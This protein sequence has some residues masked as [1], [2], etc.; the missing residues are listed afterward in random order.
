VLFVGTESGIPQVWAV[1][2]AGG[3]ARWL[4]TS[5][6]RVEA[7]RASPSGP[8]AMVFADAG[9]DENWQ[10][11]LLGLSA[12]SRG[13]RPLTGSPR[14]MH[15]P[16]AWTPDGRGY[17][18][19]SNE[20]DPRFFDV[21][22]VG[23]NDGVPHTLL[24]ADAHHEV[25]AATGD[26]T[27][28]R[29]T[30]TNLDAD[31]L[32]IEGAGSTVLTPHQGELTVTDAA[33]RDDAVYAAANPGREFTA[34]VRYRFGATSH[35]FLAEFPG[36]LEMVRAAPVGELLALVVNREGWSET[37]LFD[38]ATR[39]ERVL[40][41]GPRGVIESLSWFPDGSAFVY[42][43]SSG[44]GIDLY[45]RT[46]ATGKEKRLTGNPGAL[47]TG[48]ALPRLGR[49]T[50]SDGL[51]IP[52]WEYTPSGAV[53]GTL[54]WIHGGPEGQA[55][56]E[57]SA[58]IGFLVTEGWRVVAP[59]IRGSTGYGRKYVHLDDVRRRMDAIRDVRDVAQ[60]LIRS[61][62]ASRGRLGLLGG[63][64]G[65]FVV[66]SAASTYPDLWGAA[67]DLVGIANFVT[68]LEN[69]SPWRRPLREAE[70]GQ[71]GR[72]REF[73]EKISPLHHTDTMRA[74]LLVIHGRND[75]RV[76]VVEA[77]EIV[78]RLRKL[79]RPVELIV[80]DDEGHWIVRREN[81]LVAW[82]RAAEFLTQHLAAAPSA[83]KAPRA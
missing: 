15:L 66:L 35:E 42:T 74:P 50:A 81:Q 1:P 30:N 16:G 70:Y 18:C 28:V 19:T 65:G 3:S 60:D 64:Y 83:S 80:F 33:L 49:V 10:L 12:G 43:L 59:N 8:E 2:T 23:L 54:L 21:V 5:T 62:K 57:F 34:L 46:V 56:P 45:R 75:P 82:G 73:L 55:R 17:R 37:R 22:E 27:L 52:Y 6:D 47:P 14:V 24:A 13:A 77:E 58:E 40:N 4:A 20:R 41:S 9:G 72:D 48:L 39:E 67:V 79:R 53:R 36:D 78:A 31:L 69:T 38:V 51:A 11:T 76:P 26:R 44:D 71:L 25:L 32:M 29:R 61:G 68:F 63:S 7:V